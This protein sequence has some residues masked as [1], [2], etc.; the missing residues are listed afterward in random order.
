MKFIRNLIRRWREK[1]PVIIG[2]GVRN[3]EALHQVLL[4]KISKSHAAESRK[5]NKGRELDLDEEA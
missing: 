5:R 3:E 4:S 1:K 2:K